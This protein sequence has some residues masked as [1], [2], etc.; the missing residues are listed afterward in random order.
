MKHLQNRAR[1]IVFAT[2]TLMV[3]IVSPTF[4]DLTNTPKIFVLFITAAMALSCLLHPKFGFLDKG[5]WRV[6][7]APLVFIIVMLVLALLSDQR[8]VAF[9]GTYG[10]NNGWLQYFCFIVLFFITAYSFNINSSK[11]LLS[12]LIVLS[13]F[14]SIYGYFQY[15]GFDFIRYTDG[16]LPVIATLGNSNF[17]SAYIGICCIPTFWKITDTNIFKIRLILFGFL[18]FQLYVIYISESSQGLYI[19]LIGICLLIGYKLF[20]YNKRALFLYFSACLITS[21]T[22]LFGL[23]QLGPLTKILYQPSTTLRGDY[24]RAAWQM[25]KSNMWTGVGIDQYGDYYRVFRDTDAAFRSGG[26]NAVSNYAHNIFL[27]LLA[28]GGLLLL[29]T[30]I[31]TLVVVLFASIKGLPNYYGKNREIFIVVFAMWIAVQVQSMISVSQVT[32]TTLSWVLS[33][34]LVALTLNK[35]FIDKSTQTIINKSSKDQTFLSINSVVA[36]IFSL[37]AVFLTLTWVVPTWKAESEIKLVTNLKGSVTDPGFFEAKQRLALSAV[38]SRPG[39]IKYKILAANV[40]VEMN[41][42]DSARFQ[43]KNA[44]DQN[45]KSYES[46]IY[47]AQVYERAG[48]IVPAIKLRI[49]ASQIDRF[50]TDNWYRLGL[51]LATVGDFESIKK[52]INLLQPIENKTFIVSE[53]KNL[54]PEN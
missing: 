50:D 41:D 15:L 30:Y 9:F 1:F 6:N 17:A 2:I 54:L 10:R 34:I 24:F 27:Q 40:F 13:L 18:A 42:L 23:L 3:L 26:P 43:L 14:I 25:F 31:F 38:K 5:R 39:E 20:L 52:I 48:L 49:L 11:R 7:T 44:L 51:H 19:A 45:P 22:A 16:T 36:N 35:E 28:T 53:L 32:I 4:Y 29:I 47:S 46:L 33:G 21:I 12:I 8:Y 37:C